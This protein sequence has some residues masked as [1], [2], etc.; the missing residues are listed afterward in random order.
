MPR[1]ILDGSNITRMDIPPTH[2]SDLAGL[3]SLVDALL[4]HGLEVTCYF[5]SSERYHV[6]PAIELY[7]RCVTT[8]NPLFVQI[9]G[10]EADGPILEDANEDEAR[11]VSNDRFRPYQGLYPWLNHATNTPLIRRRV[12]TL[13]RHGNELRVAGIPE[14]PNNRLWVTRLTDEEVAAKVDS[15]CR[16]GWQQPPAPVPFPVE[17]T[18]QRSTPE[19][20]PAPQ[21]P[22]HPAVVN[23]RNRS[24]IP[25][26]SETAVI[27]QQIATAREHLTSHP[28]RVVD[29]SAAATAVHLAAECLV[30]SLWKAESFSP[31]DR[32]GTL[33]T[34]HQ[35][36][37][38][39]SPLFP[40]RSAFADLLAVQFV[41]GTVRKPEARQANDAVEAF[42]RF[43]YDHLGV[44]RPADPNRG[45]SSDDSKSDGPNRI[46]ETHMVSTATAA[47]PLTDNKS[48][49][50]HEPR[51][52]ESDAASESSTGAKPYVEITRTRSAAATSPTPPNGNTTSNQ[53]GD[54]A[55]AASRSDPPSTDAPREAV[56]AAGTGAPRA[57]AREEG[58]APRR[59]PAAT[60]M[61]DLILCPGCLLQTQPV[62]YVTTEGLVSFHCTEDD[63]RTRM[64][65]SYVENLKTHAPVSCAVVGFRGHGKTVFLS[66]ALNALRG[67]DPTLHGGWRRYHCASTDLGMHR[68]TMELVNGYRAGEMPPPTERV[69]PRPIALQ[70]QNMGGFGSRTLIVYDSTGEFV[71]DPNAMQHHALF[72]S[73]A[74]SLLLTISIADLDRHDVGTALTDL[75]QAYLLAMSA[76]ERW[77]ARSQR[78][79]IVLTKGDL[80]QSQL[81]G[82]W[83]D[84]WR[85]LVGPPHPCPSHEYAAE[86]RDN[87]SARLAD[88]LRVAHDGGQFLAL[89]E[90]NFRSV[91]LAITS[92]CQHNRGETHTIASQRVLE[93]FYRAFTPP[94]PERRS[95]REWATQ[96]VAATKRLRWSW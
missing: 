19:P 7:D 45:A 23:G 13:A 26:A 46:G 20:E 29:G 74:E 70:L 71:D 48:G 56:K 62:R 22:E 96:A 88:F 11:I 73:R 72:L 54:S 59:A 90:T 36:I 55:S 32:W 89:A 4:N 34:Y 80:L 25:S 40:D 79:G 51:H 14:C 28:T 77:Q 75:L 83:S 49:F 82:H 65:R 47:P 5:D 50:G 68:T 31:T 86:E 16:D 57:T 24:W 21:S 12:A 9:R 60:R 61:S 6:G 3:V 33:K 8:L 63:C 81:V 87:I 91:D 67:G 42:C 10:Q 94:R 95:A 39:L 85:H 43:F 30:N 84:I 64:S 15:W 92:T 37:E 41:S 69:C 27:E 1:Y 53:A 58:R 17:A 18:A 78:L 66:S 38:D 2:P 44:P 35:R 76:H 52:R 93:P